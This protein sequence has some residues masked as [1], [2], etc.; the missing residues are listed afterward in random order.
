MIDDEQPQPAH[1]RRWTAWRRRVDLDEYERRF[2]QLAA[3]GASVHG[4]VDAVDRLCDGPA[5]VLDAGCGTGR[6]AVELDRR[7]H[8]VVGVDAD[9]DM[10]QRARR[11]R[12]DLTWVEA[13]LATVELGRTFDVVLAAGNLMLFVIEGSEA[14]VVRSMARHTQPGGL[15]VCG[16]SLWGTPAEGIGLDDYDTMADAADLDLVDRW[17]TWEGAPFQGGDYAVSIHRRRDA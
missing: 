11:R 2:D 9:A 17:A 7:G 12:P 8:T 5:T 16:F 14:D 1:G 13:D 4:E 15:V 6:I 3:A 10:L